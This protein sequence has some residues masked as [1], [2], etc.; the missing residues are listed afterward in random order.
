MSSK[1]TF[2]AEM[3][4]LGSIPGV[5]YEEEWQFEEGPFAPLHYITVAEWDFLLPFDLEARTNLFE[6]SNRSKLC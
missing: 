5:L 1:D 6:V 4:A 2:K 3:E